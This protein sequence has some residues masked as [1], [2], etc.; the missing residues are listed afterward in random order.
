[1]KAFDALKKDIPVSVVTSLL[2]FNFYDLE[3]LYN[4]LVEKEIPAWQIQI[5]TAME[6]WQTGGPSF[7]TRRRCL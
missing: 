4:L 3:P 6:T 5:A 1:M 7:W 2:D